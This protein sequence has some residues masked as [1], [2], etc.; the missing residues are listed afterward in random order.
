MT[1]NGGFGQ[2]EFNTGLAAEN[3]KA[4]GFPPP[5]LVKACYKPLIRPATCWCDKKVRETIRHLSC[6]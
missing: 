5:N 3:R 2:N 6:A 4:A 1:K